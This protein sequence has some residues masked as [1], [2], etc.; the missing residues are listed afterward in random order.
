[1]PEDAQVQWPP[2]IAPNLPQAVI[3]QVWGGIDLN[4]QAG[5]AAVNQVWGNAI[6]GVFVNEA[7]EGGI[8]DIAD[9]NINEEGQV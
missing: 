2:A 1:M 8:V 9:E 3:N 5:Q 6:D 4:V 7:P